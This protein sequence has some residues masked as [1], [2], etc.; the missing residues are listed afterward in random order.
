MSRFNPSE[1]GIFIYDEP[2]DPNQPQPK[3]YG[4]SYQMIEEYESKIEQIEKEHSLFY[5]PAGDIAKLTFGVL[6][7]IALCF[8]FFG[9]DHSALYFI[10]PAILIPC[11]FI[12]NRYLKEQNFKKRDDAMKNVRSEI[13]EK[14]LKDFYE[15]YNNTHDY[16]IKYYDII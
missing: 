5:S 12:A 14:F 1:L 16:K 11:A 15:W 6:F 9:G 13:I 4:I 2:K 3:D 10:F 8:A 7:I